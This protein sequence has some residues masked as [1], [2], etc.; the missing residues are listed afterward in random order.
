MIRTTPSGSYCTQ[1]EP[2]SWLTGTRCFFRFI[3]LP[4][5]LRANS[6]SPLEDTMSP[7]QAS[8]RSRPRSWAWAVAI[9]SSCSSRSRS[10][11]RSWR[12]RQSTDRVRPLANTPRIEAT[13]SA[14]SGGAVMACAII[15]S[16]FHHVTARSGTQRRKLLPTKRFRSVN[17][18]AAA[19]S[20]PADVVRPPGVS[21]LLRRV[22][23]LFG[24]LGVDRTCSERRLRVAGRVD[25]R[26]DVTAGGQHE[27]VVLA[28]EQARAAIG[29]LP[30]ADVV[31][32][33][34]DDV[35]VGG[36]LGQV[37]RE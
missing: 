14:S 10:I 22:Q 23:P 21:E 32:D 6:A 17:L 2:G 27:A 25:Q 19:L 16:L 18:R 35:G 7:S 15:W 3:H 37:D 11:P 26:R 1:A 20:E 9:W 31:G 36:D 13:W 30:R 29:G 5:C 33:A 34:A 12:S 24:I 28:A 4:R 8:A